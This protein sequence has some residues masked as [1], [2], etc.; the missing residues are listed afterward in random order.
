MQD[1]NSTFKTL[2][3][4]MEKS[5]IEHYHDV[6][7]EMLILG[8]DFLGVYLSL[9]MVE[10]KHLLKM[11]L[12]RFLHRSVSTPKMKANIVLLRGPKN[13][14]L[15]QYDTMERQEK[16]MKVSTVYSLMNKYRFYN[17]LLIELFGA[18]PSRYDTNS[19]FPSYIYPESQV[20]VI[21]K[22]SKIMKV[23]ILFHRQNDTKCMSTKDESWSSL[24]NTLSKMKKSSSKTKH[25]EHSI[26]HLIH[27]YCDHDQYLLHSIEVE[28][29]SSR[30]MGVYNMVVEY[31]NGGKLNVDHFSGANISLYSVMFFMFKG[32]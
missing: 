16:L 19:K 2:Y 14:K 9:E 13:L 24:R 12:P 20:Q 1:G 30:L 6:E 17:G 5:E 22:Y 18:T 29:D 26:S 25:E 15:D 23:Q 3:P 4:N 11:I 28:F 31:L 8:H 21:I 32:T 27:P 10:T 7:S